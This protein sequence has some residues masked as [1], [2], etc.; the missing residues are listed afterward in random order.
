MAKIYPVRS[1]IYAKYDSEAEL[2]RELGWPRQRLN[3]ITNGTKE[4]DIRE[5]KILAEKLECPFEKLADM[6][7]RHFEEKEGA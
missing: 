2:C 5:V 6:F 7:L 3:R 1:L 4:P